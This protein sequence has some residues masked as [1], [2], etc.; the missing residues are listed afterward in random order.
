MN[1]S[2]FWNIINVLSYNSLFNYIIGERGVGKTFNS[3]EFCIKRFIKTGEQFIY[4]R[5][6]KSELKKSVPHLFDALVTENK[7]PNNNIYTKGDSLYCDNKIMGYAIPLSTSNI[8]KSTSFD[9]VKT[10]VFDEF[11]IDKGTYRYLPNEIECFL[12]LYET[13]ARL[14]DVR[15][16]FLGN[17]ISSTNPYFAYFNLHLPYNSTFATFR[18]GLIL[19]HYIKNEEYRKVKKASKFGQLIQDTQYSKYAIDNEFLRDSKYFIKHKS[20]NS[21][22]F[23][24][25]NISGN[26]FGVWRD[27]NLDEIYVSQDIDPNC[28]ISIA[29]LNDDH[30]DNTILVKSRTNPWFKSMIVHYRLG[31]LCFESQRI[32]NIVMEYLS[33]CLTY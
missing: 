17:A 4:L 25:L 6:Y 3:L 1:S 22:F 13:I 7:F 11:I 26:R 31:L 10:I 21:K 9:K 15:V 24:V 19:V 8:L 16:L 23:F 18:D 33:R 2:I 14:R 27:T 5:R 30:T 20:T 12:D 28:P 29:F 32:K